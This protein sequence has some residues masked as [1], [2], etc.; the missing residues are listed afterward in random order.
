MVQKLDS[1][2][3]ITPPECDLIIAPLKMVKVITPLRRASRGDT[4]PALKKKS[5]FEK[6]LC[7]DNA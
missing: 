1:V 7:P 3:K 4:S 2:C 5:V 6:A